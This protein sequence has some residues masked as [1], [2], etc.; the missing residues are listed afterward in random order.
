MTR[1]LQIL[2]VALAAAI[3][4]SQLF[5][6][7]GGVGFVSGLVVYLI[8][9]WTVLFAILPLQ[10]TGQHETG[11]VVAGT[12]PGA[13]VDP[14]LKHKAWLTSVVMAALWLVY[15]VVFEFSLI[16]V[17]QFFLPNPVSG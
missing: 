13:P 4:V 10:I 17:G 9:W 8:G 11:E 12:E 15:F 3:L 5:I 16:R 1:A 7:N 14:G 6:R 2:I